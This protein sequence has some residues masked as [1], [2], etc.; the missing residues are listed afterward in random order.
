MSQLATTPLRLAHIY[1]FHNRSECEAST[2]LL[3]R[4][5]VWV[6]GTMH[7]VKTD[8]YV[9]GLPDVVITAK[10]GP[11]CERAPFKSPMLK[12]I[13]AERVT[14]NQ[15]SLT[16]TETWQLNKLWRQDMYLLLL[17]LLLLP[18]R[19]R[20]PAITISRSYKGLKS[21]TPADYFRLQAPVNKCTGEPVV[22]GDAREM[23]IC[24]KG[25]CCHWQ[26]RSL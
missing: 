11:L 9:D 16:G 7:G 6:K 26:Q 22:R 5:T 12:R 15:C 25:T 1:S 17:L 23:G 10:A 13:Q 2:R 21:S 4:G 19:P 18:P 20:L 8:Q 14:G 3:C 24:V